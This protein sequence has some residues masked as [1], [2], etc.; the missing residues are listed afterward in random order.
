M[1]YKYFTAFV[2]II[3]L[4]G[5]ATIIDGRRQPILV[6]TYPAHARVF[7]E[8][9]ELG[10]TPA[11]VKVR[12]KSV[13]PLVLLSE[14]YEVKE[15]YLTKQFNPTSIYNFLDVY[16]WL[17]DWL[18]GGIHRF[19]ETSC[20]QNLVAKNEHKVITRVER[21]EAITPSDSIFFW[22]TQDKLQYADFRGFMSEKYKIF[23]AATASG[24]TCQY[25]LSDTAA[26]VRVL[27][28]FYK[29]HSFFKAKKLERKDVLTHEQQ[30]YNITEI[31]SRKLR[32]QI[33][34]KVFNRA[35]FEKDLNKLVF[36][37]FQ[38]LYA[39]QAQYDHDVYN[40]NNLF[41]M[42]K[43][44]KWNKKV[45]QELDS[46]RDFKESDIAIRF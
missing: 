33:A 44:N 14:D 16:G 30:H 23:A 10:V 27:T 7:N 36:D 37:S 4:C 8:G 28:C 32:Q 40:I 26:E 43:Q 46:L 6:N 17:V 38:D 35:T 42:G 22:N 31:I 5:C 2:C 21:L 11:I 34:S 15:V 18:T 41:E 24:I 20:V 45:T 9:K 39:F 25:V 29:N 12:R 19:K 1:N 13:A 3:L